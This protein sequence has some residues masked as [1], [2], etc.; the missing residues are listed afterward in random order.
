[1]PLYEYECKACGKA[2]EYTLSINQRNKPLEEPCECGGELKRAVGNKGGFRLKQ[3]QGDICTWA[4]EG[5]ATHV[6]DAE[7]F[8][9]EKY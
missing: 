3:N 4:K 5:Y 2:V 1:M 6:G 8:T 7:K 9:G